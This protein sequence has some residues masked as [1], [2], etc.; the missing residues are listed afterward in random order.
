MGWGGLQLELFSLR[1]SKALSFLLSARLS[2]FPY[3]PRPHLHPL[4]PGH[5]VCGQA[6][7]AH[8]CSQPQ[9]DR[10]DRSLPQGRGAAQRHAGAP[11]AG[12]LGVQGDPAGV[13]PGMVPARGRELCGACG[14]RRGTPSGELAGWLAG[15]PPEPGPTATSRLHPCLQT[16]P[17][18]PHPALPPLPPHPPA[19]RG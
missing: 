18:H 9:G 16:Q 14:C 2:G 7:G 6:P 8:L 10:Q 19:D 11:A 4:T 5:G 12:R 17:L 3:P 15:A 1:R 13:L